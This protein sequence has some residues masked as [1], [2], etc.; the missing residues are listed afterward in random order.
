M[1]WKIFLLKFLR[2]VILGV[3]FGVVALG[4]FGY[5]LAGKEGAVN[6]A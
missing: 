6:M 2:N 5:L 1:N 3:V 4:I